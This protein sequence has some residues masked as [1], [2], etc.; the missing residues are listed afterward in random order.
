MLSFSLFDCRW[1]Q[2]DPACLHP[3]EKIMDL[4][5]GG[6]IPSLDLVHALVEA[7]D[8]CG[9][10]LYLSQNPPVSL[11]LWKHLAQLLVS[12]KEEADFRDANTG[13]HA[14]VYQKEL[15]KVGASRSWWKRVYFA[16]PS[17]VDEVAEIA[18]RQNEMMEATIYRSAVAEGLFDRGVPMVKSLR[19]AMDMQHEAIKPEHIRLFRR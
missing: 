12:T 4:A 16:H 14:T 1:L 6:S 11:S 10:N 9:G 8:A 18:R 19:A 13:Q 15:H 3:L 5:S 17:T 2:N 7:V